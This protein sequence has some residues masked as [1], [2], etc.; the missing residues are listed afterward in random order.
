MPLPPSSTSAI[1]RTSPVSDAPK[2]KFSLSPG[3]T[4]SRSVTPAMHRASLSAAAPH[5]GECPGASRPERASRRPPQAPPVSAVPKAGRVIDAVNLAQARM[6]LI[7]KAAQSGKSFTPA[8]LLALQSQ[9]SQ[10]SQQLDLAGKVVEKATSG[11][12]QVLQTQI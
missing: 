5:R 1:A 6:D 9:V 11:V 12:K 8:Q 3:E 10:V 2:E 4:A 7:L